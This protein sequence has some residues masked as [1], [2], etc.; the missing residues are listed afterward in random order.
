MTH[1][2]EFIKLEEGEEQTDIILA[3]K[4]TRYSENK[5]KLKFEAIWSKMSLKEKEY[6]DRF[7]EDKVI[8]NN[9][10]MFIEKKNLK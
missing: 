1:E 7:L 2:I 4:M 5:S 10:D 3:V 9:H 8:K 6:L